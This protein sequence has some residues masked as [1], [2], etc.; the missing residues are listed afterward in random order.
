MNYNTSLKL[1]IIKRFQEKNLSDKSISLYVRNLEKL[2]DDEPLKNLNFLKDPETIIK[3]LSE[4]KKNTYRGYII[5]ICSTLNMYK[6]PQYKKLYDKYYK[7]LMEINSSL[8]KEEST[9]KKTPVQD[10]N[11]IEWKEVQN[12]HEELSKMVKEFENN[13][14]I[15][16]HKYDTLLKYVILSL[17]FYVPPKRNQDWTLMNIVYKD[18]DKL[19]TDKN[20]YDYTNNKFIFNKYKTSRTKGCLIEDVPNELKKVFDIYLKFHP[21]LNGK[22]P[23][24]K[25]NTPLL[26]YQDGKDLSSINSITRILNRIFD[27]NIG[28]SMLRHIYLSSKYGSTLK[29]MKEDANIMAHSVQTAMNSYIKV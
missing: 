7:L 1:D 19:S 18:D 25:T 3:K 8:K 11:W 4:Y 24:K 14:V 9:N 23:D 6:T 5:A 29:N 22:K 10:E 20:Y 15:N 28:S 16:S 27:K 12:K 26:V 17:Y 21:V 13:K 2:N